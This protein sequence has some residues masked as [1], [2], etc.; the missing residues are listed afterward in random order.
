LELADGENIEPFIMFAVCNENEVDGFA[1][2]YYIPGG[3]RSY[4]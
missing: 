1:M 2:I 3:K 4:V